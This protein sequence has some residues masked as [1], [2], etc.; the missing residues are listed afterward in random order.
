MS[1][2]QAYL[3]NPRTRQV[4]N[5]KPGEKGFSL[6]ELVVVIA[7]LAVLTAIA[8][9]N[10]LGVSD[11]A[12]GRAA[13]QGAITAFKEC[14]VAKA[15]GQANA[16]S[17][18][19]TPAINGF[20]IYAN[21]RTADTGAAIGTAVTAG[22]ANQAAA[23]AA[24]GTNATASTSC[25]TGNGA[26]DGAIRDILA[27]PVNANE[28]PVYKVSNSGNK[29]CVTGTAAAGATTFNIGCDSTTDSTFATGWK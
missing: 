4:L 20:I 23:A 28:F 1:L 12:T 26:A 15:R 24:A 25:F 5:R 2:L 11:D 19:A 7:V 21:D 29:F 10:F 22:P 18:F 14:Q 16:N 9:P 8:L 17:T 13:Q 6:I 3:Q 27:I